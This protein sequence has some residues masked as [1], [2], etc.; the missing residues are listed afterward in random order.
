MAT[1]LA[2]CEI[3]EGYVIIGTTVLQAIDT[4]KA[5]RPFEPFEIVLLDPPYAGPRAARRHLGAVNSA[6]TDDT[7]DVLQ[8]VGAIVAANGVVVLEHDAKHSP[9][10][11][12][13]TL[14]RTRVLVSGDSGL[15][16]YSCQP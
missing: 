3:T 9:P 8:A 13:G 1:N 5:Q 12:P 6:A 2:R 15:T 4:L 16:F 7:H 11:A 14:R 10:A